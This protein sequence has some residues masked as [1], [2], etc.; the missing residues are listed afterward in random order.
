MLDRDLL[1]YVT[2]LGI[3]AWALLILIVAGGAWMLP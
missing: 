3:A 1:A 2:A